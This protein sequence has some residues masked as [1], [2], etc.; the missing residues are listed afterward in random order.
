MGLFSPKVAPKP[1]AVEVA[2][3]EQ[4]E[5]LSL[6]DEVEARLARSNEALG[7]AEDESVTS[8]SLYTTLIEQEQ[9]KQARIAEARAKNERVVARV[10]ALTE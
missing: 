9:A 3:T 6:F 2:L 1:D 8:V 4:S 5:A 7:Q 10:R